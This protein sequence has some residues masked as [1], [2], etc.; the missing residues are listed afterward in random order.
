MNN[1]FEEQSNLA[2]PSFEKKRGVAVGRGES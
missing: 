1:N 2:G